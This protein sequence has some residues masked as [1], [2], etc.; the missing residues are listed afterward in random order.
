[1]ECTETIH[2]I[3]AWTKVKCRNCRTDICVILCILMESVKLRKKA[4][5][6]ILFSLSGKEIFHPNPQWAHDVKM[7][8]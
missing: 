3:L 1:M 6:F 4:D 2:S 8:M 7:M 5:E